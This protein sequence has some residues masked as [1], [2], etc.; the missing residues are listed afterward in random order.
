VYECENVCEY[1]TE[2]EERERGR[3]RGVG[4]GDRN[5]KRGKKN[6]FFYLFTVSFP[7]TPQT[8]QS[9]RE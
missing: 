4:E 9:L 6:I 7:E 8:L 2:R 5:S 3:E 1:E